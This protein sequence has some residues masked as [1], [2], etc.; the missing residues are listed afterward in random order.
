[1]SLK[2]MIWVMED[3]P[4]DNPAELVVL[5]ALAD[6][7]SD[8]GEAAF[9]SQ[10]WIAER[11][12]CSERTVRRRLQD[13]EEKG[14]IRRGDHR[15]VEHYRADRR[16][17]VWDLNMSLTRQSTAGQNG[18]PSNC[19]AGQ[20]ESNGRTKT[21]LRPDTVV[22]QTVQNHPEPKEGASSSKS[23][24]EEPTSSTA[25]AAIG[26]P[27]DWS[28]PE[29]PRCKKHASL[30]ADRVPACRAC[31][32]ARK[33]FAT[34]ADTERQLA[35]REIDA[36]DI[37]D[38]RGLAY[39]HQSG[40]NPIAVTCNHLSSPLSLRPTPVPARPAISKQAR[41]LQ[42]KARLLVQ[43]ARKPATT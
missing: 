37:C 19:P 24:V 30:P 1:M 43:Q 4:V 28:T 16:P 39:V 10:S 26:V 5:Y 14:L 11:A 15:L 12:R 6:R 3:A 40:G 21:A 2:A 38:D 36:C 13:L 41:D 32:Q 7:A 29:D 35:R 20:N 42:A 25:D 22:L 27:S 31:G 34:K 23:S 8:S 18:P 9:P 17:V 33:W